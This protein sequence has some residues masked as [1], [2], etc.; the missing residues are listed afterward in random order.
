MDKPIA[1]FKSSMDSYKE[2]ASWLWYDNLIKSIKYSI[3]LTLWSVM[4]ICG[5][6]LALKSTI[7]LIHTIKTYNLNN[8]RELRRSLNQNQNG[9]R[10]PLAH[11][12]EN[13]KITVESYKCRSC[14]KDGALS[15]REIVNIPCMHMYN[16]QK[17]YEAQHDDST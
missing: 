7:G 13:K 10:L 1:F 17:C 4:T 6:Y 2:F 15:M 9:N 11:S 5:A 3:K 8:H 12:I 14:E 16:C